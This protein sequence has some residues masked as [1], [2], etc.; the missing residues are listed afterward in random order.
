MPQLVPAGV[1][2]CAAALGV[3]RSHCLTDACCAPPQFGDVVHVNLGRVSR[4]LV[5][6]EFK[7]R[8]QLVV[9]ATLA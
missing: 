1:F 6:V 5:E 4:G 8:E 9:R 3:P 2:L 7:T